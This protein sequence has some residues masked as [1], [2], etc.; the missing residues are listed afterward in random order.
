MAELLNFN[1]RTDLDNCII[2]RQEPVF[3]YP[4]INYNGD[5]LVKPCID[6]KRKK[7]KEKKVPVKDPKHGLLEEITTTEVVIERP[8]YYLWKKLRDCIFTL[9]P[10]DA[11]EETEEYKNTKTE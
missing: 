4:L 6:T 10:Y 11:I 9:T 7:R 1:R 5:V 3:G 8:E 2:S